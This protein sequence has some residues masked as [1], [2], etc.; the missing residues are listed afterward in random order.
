[1]IHEFYFKNGYRLCKGC[2]KYG[3]VLQAEGTVQCGYVLRFMT[4]TS[5]H[6]YIGV[7]PQPS[8]HTSVAYVYLQL[9]IIAALLKLTVALNISC[10][11]SAAELLNFSI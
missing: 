1:M 8:E 5:G 11:H 3:Y 6:F 7:A 2:F 4:H 9:Q 10:T